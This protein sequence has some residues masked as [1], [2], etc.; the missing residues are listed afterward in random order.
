MI[1]ELVKHC[2]SYYDLKFDKV[3]NRDCGDCGDCLKKIH[4]P[5]GTYKQ[6]DCIVMCHYYV[7]HN[8]YRY[9]TEMM[10]LFHEEALR[11][12]ARTN[13]IRMCSIG[14]GPCSELVAF[15]EYY[16]KKISLLNLHL[17]VLTQIAYGILSRSM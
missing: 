9:T 7:C 13:P 15:E 14:C 4:Y 1:Q 17:M 2:S 16:K 5:L 3:S 8:I 6:Y 11:F 10:W 12:K